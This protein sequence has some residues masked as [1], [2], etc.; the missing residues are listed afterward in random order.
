M[1]GQFDAVYLRCV[2]PSAPARRVILPRK[3]TDAKPTF[4]R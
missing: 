3:A 2:Q 1:E 4:R